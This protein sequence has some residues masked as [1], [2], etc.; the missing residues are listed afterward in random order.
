MWAFLLAVQL[1]ALG[2]DDYLLTK[3]D[4]VTSYVST[5]GSYCA[6]KNIHVLDHPLTEVSQHS[7]VN[8][9]GPGSFC[10]ENAAHES[11][12]AC[13]GYIKA[14]DTAEDATDVVCLAEADCEELCGRLPRA[15]V[16]TWRSTSCTR[17]GAT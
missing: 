11:C 1:R 14:Y 5:E 9:C 8:K 3:Y 16:L 6:G 10:E 12:V 15:T 2:E 13:D 17:S 4:P 7:C